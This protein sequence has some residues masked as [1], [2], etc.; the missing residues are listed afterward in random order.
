MDPSEMVG[1]NQLNAILGYYQCCSEKSSVAQNMF[2][3][4]SRKAAGLLILFRSL[5]KIT[6]RIIF[7][8]REKPMNLSFPRFSWMF[9]LGSKLFLVSDWGWVIASTFTS[10]S[11]TFTT[12]REPPTCWY[13]ICTHSMELHIFTTDRG[14]VALKVPIASNF[15]TRIDLQWFTYDFD[16]YYHIYVYIYIYIY[17]YIFVCIH[18]YIFIYT[19][20]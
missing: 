5:Q 7:A 18:I 14:P 2:P 3:K 1:L 12:D 4:E 9:T 17:I 19:D 11:R 10:S 20:I 13:P 15:A 6:F 8:N 16:C